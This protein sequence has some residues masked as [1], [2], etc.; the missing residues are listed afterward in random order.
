MHFCILLHV[1]TVQSLSFPAAPHSLVICS[2]SDL[3][4]VSQGVSLCCIQSAEYRPITCGCNKGVETQTVKRE[5]GIVSDHLQQPT[6]IFPFYKF[7]GYAPEIIDLG[8]LCF[9]FLPSVILV[10]LNYKSPWNSVLLPFRPWRCPTVNHQVNVLFTHS[11]TFQVI[12]IKS[13]FNV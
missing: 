8:I 7:V 6:G 4:P 13:F 5:E 10:S 1:G 12:L 2:A 9:F 3:S 11:V